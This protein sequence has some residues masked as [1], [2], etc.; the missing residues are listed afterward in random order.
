MQKAGCTTAKLHN[1]VITLGEWG[2][3]MGAKSTDNESMLMQ[4]RSLEFN[5]IETRWINNEAMQLM[6]SFGKNNFLKDSTVQVNMIHNPVLYRY[7][8]DGKWDMY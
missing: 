2:W 5:D 3:I 6:T 7:Y 8:L 4:L 1:Q